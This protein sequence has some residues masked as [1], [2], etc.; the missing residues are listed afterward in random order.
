M[1]RGGIPQVGFGSWMQGVLV[2][3]GTM[4]DTAK[5]VSLHPYMG[6][7]WKTKDIPV[8]QITI[9][10]YQTASYSCV[11]VLRMRCDY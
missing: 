10:V 6:A 4:E 1:C 7:Y 2:G 8:H 11:G 5:Q 3:R 9:P